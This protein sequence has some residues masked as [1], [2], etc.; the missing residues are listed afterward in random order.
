MIIV[1]IEIIEFSLNF[2][3]YT[4]IEH[5]SYFRGKRV[6]VYI[7]IMIVMYS[8]TQIFVNMIKFCKK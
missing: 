8:N 1:I 4:F 7:I 2:Y 5:Y 6:H 3:L